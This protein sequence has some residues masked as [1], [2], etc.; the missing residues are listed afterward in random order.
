MPSCADCG[1]SFTRPASKSY[2]I[3]CYECYVKWKEYCDAYDPTS[4]NIRYEFVDKYGVQAH[5]RQLLQLCHP[6]KHA[7]SKTASDITAWLLK[8]PRY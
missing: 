4:D 8:I 2:L 3:R 7:G 1:K 6:D 5:V